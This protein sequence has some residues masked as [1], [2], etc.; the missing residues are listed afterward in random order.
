MIEETNR[1]LVVDG[2]TCEKASDGTFNPADEV[3]FT[4]KF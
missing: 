1:S 3:D 4:N 2:C